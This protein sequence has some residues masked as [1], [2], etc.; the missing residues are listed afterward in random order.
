MGKMP[1]VNVLS[2]GGMDQFIVLSPGNNVFIFAGD[3]ESGKSTLARQ[4]AEPVKVI[5]AVCKFDHTIVT[6]IFNSFKKDPNIL[7][8][9]ITNTDLGPHYFITIKNT[10]NERNT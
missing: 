5:D 1:Y 10:F 4:F 9:I 7:Q 8:I 3:P 6:D 2:G